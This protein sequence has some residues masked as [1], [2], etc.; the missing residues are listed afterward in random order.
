MRTRFFI[1]IV[2]AVTNVALSKVS[3]LFAQTTYAYNQINPALLKDADAVIRMDETTFDIKSKG[4]ARYTHHYAVTILNEAGEEKYKETVVAYDK[5]TKII[6]ISGNVYDEGGNVLKKLRGS[7]IKDYGYGIFGDDVTDARFRL[8]DLGKKSFP[9]PYTVEFT[10]ETKDRNMM[11]YPRWRPVSEPSIA[12]EQAIFK[13]KAPAGFKFRYKEYNGAPVMVKSTGPEGSDIYSWTMKDVPVSKQ[14]VYALP[15][16]DSEAMV[17]TAPL[18]FEIQDY[19]NG[20]FDSWEDL[21]VFYYTLNTGRDVLP[22]GIVKEINALIKNAK[23][24]REKVVLIYKWMQSRSRYVSIQLG[25]GGWQTIDAAT[26]SN[27]GYGDCKAL[28]NFTLAALKQAGITSYAALIRAGKEAQI[29]GDFPSN[30]FNHVIACAIAEKDTIWLEC[31]SQITQANRMGNFTNNRPALLVMPKGGKL[32]QIPGNTSSQNSRLSRVLVNLET[33]GN[34]RVEVQTVYSGL[35][36]DTR[37]NLLH[38][39]A[40]EEQKKW[41]LGHTNLPSMDLQQFEFSK[42]NQD[43]PGIVEKLTLNVRNCATKTGTRLFVKTSLLSRPLALPASSERK[44]DFYLPLSDYDFTDID[45]LSYVVPQGYKLESTLPALQFSSVFGTFE[46]KTTFE[47][48]RMVSYRKVILNGGRYKASD[49]PV[50]I[51][52]LKKIRK[53]DRTQVVFVEDKD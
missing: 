8:A 1:Y 45:S 7:D 47:N 3:P 13:V 24:E 23:T 49:Y 48:N 30:Q 31:T 2:I 12:V 28:T 5:F 20:K 34:A 53:A 9:Y 6:D 27:K 39:A 32:V 4:E 22:E 50:W 11:S 52:F 44:T 43:D 14:E 36:K 18:D 21:S 41:L 10:Y 46:C 33:G 25:I 38:T 37:E 40:K 26:V 42:D 16:G 51:D 19:Y 17:L 35:Q 29:K 15:Y